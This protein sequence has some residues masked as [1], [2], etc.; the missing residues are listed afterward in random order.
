M[1]W[2]KRLFNSRERIH[3]KDAISHADYD[4]AEYALPWDE[5]D[6]PRDGKQWM[7]DYFT[8]KKTRSK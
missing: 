2:F 4:N 1:G 3:W 6:S 5:W 7:G 8:D